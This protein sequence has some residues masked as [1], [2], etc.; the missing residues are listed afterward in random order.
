MTVWAGTWRTSNP[1]WNWPV[2]S[3]GLAGQGMTNPNDPIRLAGVWYVPGI[4]AALPAGATVTAAKLRLLR[5]GGVGESTLVTPRL[6][7]HTYTAIP[8]GAPTW[9][10]TAWSPGSLAD[11]Q[12]GVWDL[13]STWL[14]AL[15]AGTATGVGVDSAAWADYTWFLGLQI[16]LSYSV[17]A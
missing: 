1:V 3:G 2:A 8:S 10:G 14:T 13:P 6:R 16:N 5:W 7:M 4:S 12:T 9:T 17:P 15:L 11:Q